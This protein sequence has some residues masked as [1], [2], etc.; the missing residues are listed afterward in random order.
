LPIGP[1]KSLIADLTKLHFPIIQIVNL[2]G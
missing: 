2:L 1:V